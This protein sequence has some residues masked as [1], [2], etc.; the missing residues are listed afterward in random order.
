MYILAIAPFFPL[1]QILPGIQQVKIDISFYEVSKNS[2]LSKAAR[3]VNHLTSHD[4]Q[5]HNQEQQLGVV[6]AKPD[7]FTSFFLSFFRAAVT[8]VNGLVTF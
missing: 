4:E 3:A 5:H 2:F 1:L 6:A 7:F 8:A